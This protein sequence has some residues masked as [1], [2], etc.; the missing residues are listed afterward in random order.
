MF[1]DAT[2]SEDVVVAWDS[3]AIGTTRSGSTPTFYVVAPKS[4]RGFVIVAGDDRVAP[5]LAY[6]TEFCIGERYAT[7]KF[8]G[9]AAL[10]R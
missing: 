7:P 8:R 5:I 3:G 9:V 10:R 2:R 1:G 4:G 6:S